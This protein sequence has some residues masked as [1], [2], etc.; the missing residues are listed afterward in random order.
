MNVYYTEALEEGRTDPAS[1]YEVLECDWDEGERHDIDITEWSTKPVRSHVHDE[2]VLDHLVERLIEFDLEEAGDEYGTLA[3]KLEG[4]AKDV[5]VQTGFRLFLDQLFDGVSWW[6]ADEVVAK[7]KITHDDNGEP[8]FDGK[9]L[10]VKRA[11]D[12]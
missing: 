6:V 11:A 8:L 2:H 7:H 12:A 4:R 3:E 5:D 1:L 10:Y 9:P